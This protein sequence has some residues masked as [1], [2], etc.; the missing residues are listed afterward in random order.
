[1]TCSA[2]ARDN[3]DTMND[4]QLLRYSR[5]IMLPEIDA[6][7]QLRLAE[8][9]VLVIGLGGL[10]SAVTIY[11]AAAGVGHLVL[12]D[13][14]DVALSN[15]QRQILYTTADIGRAKIEAA[16]EHLLS[17]NPDV[18]IY[19]I[20]DRLTAEKYD[21][22]FA[23]ADLVLDCS[24]NFHTR[25][26]INAAC[27]THRVPLVSAAAI[28]FEAQISVFDPRRDDSPCYRCLYGE[29]AELDETCTANG[30]VAPL[31]G[32]VGSV[33]A[34]EALKLLMHIGQPLTGRLLLLDAMTMQW[35][36]A[37]LP[38]DPD[39]PVCGHARQDIQRHAAASDS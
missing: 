38:K 35:H 21:S 23:A 18:S 30:V 28:R 39:C 34:M 33:Q 29:A 14:D 5:Q 4:E 26:A 8:S 19:T 31:L 9:R 20:G 3:S 11:L 22:E 15:L 10:G 16:R 25:F 32:I 13:D 6:T 36:T 7:G 37:K 17:L 27:V 1:M 2:F 24:D 12:I